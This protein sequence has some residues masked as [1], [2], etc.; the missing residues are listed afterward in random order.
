MCVRGRHDQRSDHLDPVQG[1]PTEAAANLWHPAVTLIVRP[2]QCDQRA[3]GNHQQKR[4]A[5]PDAGLG[6]ALA[7]LG[8]VAWARDSRIPLEVSCA[9]TN[10]RSNR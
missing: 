6:R 4:G 5:R 9:A 3:A 7:T 8:R 2:P 1:N 10:A